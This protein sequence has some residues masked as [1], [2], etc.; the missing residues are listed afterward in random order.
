MA[1]STSSIFRHW[2]RVIGAG[3]LLSA[4]LS[5]IAGNE[6]PASAVGRTLQPQIEKARAGTCVEE[7][8]FMRRNHM[9]LLKHQR[10]DTLRGG[11]RTGKY[12]LKKCVA[13]HASPISQSVNAEAG[14]FC[15]SCHNYAAVKIDCFECHANTPP[16]NA[17]Q[18][19]VSEKK[20]G[21]QPVSTQIPALVAS[22]QVRP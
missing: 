16:A 11:V 22:Q 20:A 12:S 5:A 15:Q 6:A 1:L 2:C 10:D 19:L 8:A 4:G 13:C 21:N 9:K 14:N 17:A 7:P 18:P 3:L